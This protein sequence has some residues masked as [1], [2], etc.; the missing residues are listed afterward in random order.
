M[1]ALLVEALEGAKSLAR[2]Y[3]VLTGRRYWLRIK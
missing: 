2:A 1:L 3:Y